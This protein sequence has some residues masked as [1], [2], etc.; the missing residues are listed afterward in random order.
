MRKIKLTKNQYALV[1]NDDYDFIN[2][3]KWY[4]MKQPNTYYACRDVRRRGKK[5][6]LWMHRLINKTPRK[7]KTDHINGNGIDNRKKNLRTATHQQNMINSVRR[8]KLY[9]KYRGVTWHKRNQVWMAQI[10]M[11][12]KNVYLGDFKTEKAAS[13][14]YWDFVNKM[15]KNKPFRKGK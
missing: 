8:K 6:T 12:Y 9:S 7:L 14:A 3:W 4:A 11:N 5:R 1:D 10:T 15:C 2:K 13:N